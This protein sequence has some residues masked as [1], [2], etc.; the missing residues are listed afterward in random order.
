M[1]NHQI[2]L[3]EKLGKLDYLF[4]WRFKKDNDHTTKNEKSNKNSDNNN[5]NSNAL[6]EKFI[7]N[8]D[9]HSL[10]VFPLEERDVLAK[11]LDREMG[12]S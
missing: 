5:S 12:F 9:F 2:E 1:N 6:L 10:K 7:T 8:I 4:F 3:A 11:L